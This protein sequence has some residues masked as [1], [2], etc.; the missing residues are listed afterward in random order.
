[1]SPRPLLPAERVHPAVTDILSRFHR[2]TVDEV[3]QTV[4][5]DRWVVVGMRQ[6]PVVKKARAFLE[7]EGIA[8]T[9]LEYGSYLGEWKRRLAIKLWAGF[10]TYPMIFREGV[11]LGGLSEL[12][13]LKER[14]EL[15][16]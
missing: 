1:M 12:V 15:K 9:Y 16:P 13:A 5:R 3:E 8:F 2:S 14:G 10:P 11:L 7:R 4:A 6:N